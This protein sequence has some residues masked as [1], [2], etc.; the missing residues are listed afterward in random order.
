MSVD[1]KDLLK[2]SADAAIA[3]VRDI[4]NRLLGPFADQVGGLLTDPIRVWRYELS[5]KLFEKVKKIAEQADLDL[6]T[7]P[8]KQLLPILEYASVEDDTDLH[9]RWANLLTNA[10]VDSSRVR[11]FF[12]DALRQLG[13]REAQLL[14]R[15]RDMAVQFSAQTF[16]S[17]SELQ[18]E[19]LRHHSFAKIF[20]AYC[21]VAGVRPDPSVFGPSV[22]GPSVSGVRPGLILEE[23]AIQLEQKNA[24]TNACL[25][26]L[27]VLVALGFV[28]IVNPQG[29]P[30]TFCSYR[31]SALGSE[32]VKAC[33][34][35][36][37]PS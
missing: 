20:M 6:K 5:V 30:P 1:E 15:I 3:P 35:P 11:M 32:F 17:F 2:V 16:A 7:V 10:A 14:D 9:D 23:V 18:E 12:P 22:S 19:D 4:V 8:L 34:T 27:Y 26:S 28:V 36:T 13:P 29:L 33:S 25:A 37:K 24:Q 31:I 21:Q